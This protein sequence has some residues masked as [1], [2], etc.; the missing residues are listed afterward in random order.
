[1]QAIRLKNLRSFLD[2]GVVPLNKINVFVGQN[3]S[4]KSTFLRTFPLLRQ[5]VL[6]DT[7]GPILWYDDTLVDFGSYE[8]AKSRH[9]ND[10]DGIHFGFRISLDPQRGRYYYYDTISLRNESIADIDIEI[11]EHN[12][13]NYIGKI[14]I[15]IE[16]HEI[17]IE[18]NNIGQVKSFQVNGS[19]MLF[20]E[21]THN[22]I[23]YDTVGLIPQM[24]ILTKTEK[25]INREYYLQKCR[26]IIKSII[27]KRL[28][29]EYRITRMITDLTF[30][31]K[32]NI[33]NSLKHESSILTWVKKIKNWNLE[34]A[35]FIQLNNLI[36]A[37]YT[38]SILG[39]IDN[40]LKTYFDGCQYI[41][42]IRAKAIRYYRRQDLSVSEID[43]YGDNLHMFLDNLNKKQMES[44]QNFV[45]DVFDFIP[46][47]ESSKGHITIN[48]EDQNGEKFNITDLGFGYSQILPIITKLWYTFS[49]NERP[50]NPWEPREK[51]ITLLIE[52]PE[53]HLHPAMQAQLA[54]AF[55]LATEHAKSNDVN[56]KLIIETHSS[57]IIN[58]IGRRVI[59]KKLDSS[60]VSVT[61]FQL[62]AELKNST[63]KS[64]NFNE[65]GVLVN[66]PIG[67]FE[68][69]N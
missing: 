38:S 52:Q 45:K 37:H 36:V 62:D 46:S 10:K 18:A 11:F 22:L 17:L 23:K 27:G 61:L 9:A 60:A 67:F 69:N 57:V 2:T 64:T 39:V 65:N 49:D 3:S 25:R 26:E 19:N 20:T 8:E 6:R 5:S 44:Y 7:R 54:D 21:G 53:L 16:D 28:K 34:T 59:E 47:T 48:I 13:K 56:L 24:L 35:E 29:N 1:M 68:P 66:W 32:E 15:L 14:R 51:N 40:K 33:L 31:K 63:I 42:P 12:K 58:R 55:I 4:G 50:R 41:A 30:D 43:A